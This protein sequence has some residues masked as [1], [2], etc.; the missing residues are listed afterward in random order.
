MVNHETPITISLT[1]T[2]DDIALLDLALHG[3]VSPELDGLFEHILNM[4]HAVKTRE[5]LNNV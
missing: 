1:L 3:Y 2:D 5:C 4:A